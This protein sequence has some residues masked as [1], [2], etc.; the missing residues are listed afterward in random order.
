MVSPADNIVTPAT[1]NGHNSGTT[2]TRRGASQKLHVSKRLDHRCED[3]ADVQLGLDDALRTRIDRQL[4]PQSQDLDID[5]TI[6]NI[7]VQPRGS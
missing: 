5:A 6:E 1:L 2:T 4:A 7:L 3:I